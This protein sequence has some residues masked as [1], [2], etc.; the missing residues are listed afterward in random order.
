MLTR[1]GGE[2]IYGASIFSETPT[3]YS[4]TTAIAAS[5][6]RLHVLGRMWNGDRAAKN[7]SKIYWRFGAVTINAASVLRVSIQ[8]VSLTAGPP[9]RGDGTVIRSGTVAGSDAKFAT[10][11]WYPGVSLGSVYAANYGDLFAV[12]FELTTFNASDSVIV[13]GVPSASLVTYPSGS[14][15][16][17]VSEVGG[18]F[19]LGATVPV[20]L[21]EFDDGTF[22]TFGG[23]LPFSNVAATAFNSGTTPDEYCLEFSMPL[24]CTICG[25]LVYLAVAAGADFSVI[26][27]SGTTALQTVSVD[28]STISVATNGR[29]YYVEFPETDLSASTTYRIAVRPDTANNVTLTYLDVEVATHFQAHPVEQNFCVNTRT[30][31]GAWGSPTTTRRYHILPKFSRFDNGAGGSGGMIMSRVRTGF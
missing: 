24:P 17:F 14:A 1:L 8:A 10:N 6:T 4:A 2:M 18:V 22:G 26:L 19:T 3:G 30:N 31:A 9:G 20:I 7:I 11:T 29:W 23:T 5:T 21:F 16:F 28:A 25:A 12:V 13:S 27:Y 15:N